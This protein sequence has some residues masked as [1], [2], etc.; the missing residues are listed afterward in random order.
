MRSKVGCF[1]D[2]G[3]T[4]RSYD[5]AMPTGGNLD[6]PFGE[7]IGHASRIFVVASHVDASKCPLQVF[8]LLFRR[9]LGLIFF[10]IG[11]V[12]FGSMTVLK[13]R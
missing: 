11:Q 10:H 3:T 9:S 5:K 6:R 7:Q 12:R 13:A 2:A 4:S 8:L 1:H